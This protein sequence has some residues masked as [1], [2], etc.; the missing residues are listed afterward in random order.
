MVFLFIAQGKQK[1]FCGPPA[2]SL[3]LNNTVDER[4]Q[5]VVVAAPDI[6]AGM[7]LGAT[8]PIDDVSRPDDFAAEFL[9]AEL[10]PSESRPLRE[11]PTPFL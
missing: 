4:K 7:D 10:W 3:V 2:Q 6:I 8:L 11:L 5:R 9:A 1:L